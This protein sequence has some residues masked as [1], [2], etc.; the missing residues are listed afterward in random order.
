VDQAIHVGATGGD[1]CRAERLLPE[2]LMVGH[3]RATHCGRAEGIM[4]MGPGYACA[5]C[6]TML[7]PRKNDVC[8]HVTMNDGRPY[9]LWQAD[10]WE[11]PDCGWQAV[12]GYGQSAWAEH[13]QPDFGKYLAQV[14]ITINGELKALP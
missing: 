4:S 3:T 10:L 8:V 2:M 5:N 9:Q 13:Y 6:K 14:D 12:L 7:R 1:A 11:C